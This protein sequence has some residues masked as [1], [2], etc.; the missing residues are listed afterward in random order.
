MAKYSL[1]HM[2]FMAAYMG[3]VYIPFLLEIKIA[4]L[5]PLFLAQCEYLFYMQPMLTQSQRRTIPLIIF[6]D[7]NKLESLGMLA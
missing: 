1:T 5:G 3:V 6:D 2:L 7:L 4:L